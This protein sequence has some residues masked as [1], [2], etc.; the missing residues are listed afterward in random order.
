M[1]LEDASDTTKRGG[2]GFSLG[3]KPI[4]LLAVYP[5]LV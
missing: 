3:E 1:I 2:T 4:E 5:E